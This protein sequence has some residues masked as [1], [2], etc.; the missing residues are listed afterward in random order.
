MKTRLF[1]NQ[2]CEFDG[3]QPMFPDAE[4]TGSVK[5]DLGLR[6][7]PDA[8][9]GKPLATAAREILT[10][11]KSAGMTQAASTDEIYEALTAGGFQF[12]SNDKERQKMGVSVSLAKNSVTFR[13]LPNGLY[14]LADWYGPSK[15]MRRRRPIN[16]DG[17]QDDAGEGYEQDEAAGDT[18]ESDPAASVSTPNSA[19]EDG[20][21]VVHDN[22]NH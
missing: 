19:D 18:L 9:F 2:I 11:R 15:P 13:K 17:S 5:A 3:R 14:G 1:I 4:M 12:P 6:I 20:R 21:E 8:F 22:M 16:L 7:A 10:M